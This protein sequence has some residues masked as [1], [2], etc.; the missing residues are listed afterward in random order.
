MILPKVPLKN[1][2][3]ANVF[4]LMGLGTRPKRLRATFAQ[5]MTTKQALSSGI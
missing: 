4:Y 2:R 3:L 1:F 5:E